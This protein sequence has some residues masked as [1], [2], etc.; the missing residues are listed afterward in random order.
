MSL[1]EAFRFVEPGVLADGEL[2]LVAPAERWVEPLMETLGHPLTRQLAPDDAALTREQ[3]RRFVRDHPQGRQRANP[4]R[5][6]V[7]AYYFWMRLRGEGELGRFGDGGEPLG[8]V[9]RRPGITIVG[10]IALRV[11]HTENL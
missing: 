5:G 1:L 2:E 10:G 3:I 8:R 9:R 11:G 7:P 4:E 6:S